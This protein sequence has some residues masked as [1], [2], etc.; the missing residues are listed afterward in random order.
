[1]SHFVKKIRNIDLYTYIKIQKG[2]NILEKHYSVIIEEIEKKLA[3]IQTFEKKRKIMGLSEEEKIKVKNMKQEYF[4]GYEEMIEGVINVYLIPQIHDAKCLKLLSDIQEMVPWSGGLIIRDADFQSITQAGEK[5]TNKEQQKLKI[6]IS[7][8]HVKAMANFNEVVN[9]SKENYESIQEYGKVITARETGN[10]FDV[11]S[12]ID[13]RYREFA[14]MMGFELPD[15]I[16]EGEN[17]E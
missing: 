16:I 14:E 11:I 7:K 13:S 3:K 10:I 8:L 17:Q 9:E 6:L 4:L 5:L 2:D 12:Y 15:V 1:L